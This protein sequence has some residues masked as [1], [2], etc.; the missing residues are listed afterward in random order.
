MLAFLVSALGWPPFDRGKSV[1]SFERK[2]YC[3]E[4]T[5]FRTFAE[6]RK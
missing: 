5:C 3:S 2:G 4:E 6:S 1:R